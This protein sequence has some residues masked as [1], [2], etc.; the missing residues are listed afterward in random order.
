MTASMDDGP[1]SV[2]DRSGRDTVAG[3]DA[4]GAAADFAHTESAVRRRREKAVALA[5]FAWDR[6]ISGAELSSLDEATLRGLARAADV[7]PPSS[8]DT[9]DLAV[10][11]LESKDAWAARNADRPEAVRA[12]PEEKIMWIKP[13]IPGWRPNR[14]E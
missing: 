5:R 9:W 4:S 6:R 14:S 10:D 13:P 7:H 1:G 2:D 12:H 8:R 11:L 3:H